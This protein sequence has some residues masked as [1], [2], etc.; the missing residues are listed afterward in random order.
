MSDQIRVAVVGLGAVARSVHLPILT[1]R[2]DKFTIVGICDLSRDAVA[3]AG[4]RFGIAHRFD[5]LDTMLDSTDAE[6]LAVLSSG[7]HVESILAGL[8]R[9]L[10]VFCEKPVA[11]TVREAETI[12]T[13]L[14]GRGDKLM[15]GYMKV[16]DPA[17]IEAQKLLVGRTAR[18][19]EV[20]VLHP[21]SEAQLSISDL[22]PQPTA[23]PRPIAERLRSKSRDMERE[24]L[25]EAATELGSLY[26]NVLLGSLIH[27]LAVLRTLG[28]PLASVDHA[29]RWPQDLT[30]MSVAVH[31]RTADDVRL[32]LRWH[33]LSGYPSYREEI[34]WHDEGG[35]VEIVFPSPYLLRVPTE[36][37]ASEGV[38]RGAVL[39]T[40]RSHVEAFEE[41]MLAFYRMVTDGVAPPNGIAEGLE[42]VRACQQ[43][44]AKLAEREG[45]NLGG[46]AARWR[47]SV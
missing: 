41:E 23:V 5:D 44:V 7:S 39:R 3:A 18:S 31:A 22:D 11:Y 8:K 4:D 24:A 6:A 35:S 38:E 1:R 25:G 21:A 17:V 20:V 12:A 36:L 37:R 47:D 32:S 10:P 40:F 14:D 33:H 34:R 29:D 27:D 46:E 45:L 2:S 30:D 26:T 42:D 28:A 15:I 19:I 43:I 13:A 16:H 9:E